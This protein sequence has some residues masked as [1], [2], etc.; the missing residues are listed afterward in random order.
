MHNDVSM[1][2]NSGRTLTDQEQQSIDTTITAE[3]VLAAIHSFKPDSA[4]VPMGLPPGLYQRYA[5]LYAPLLTLLLNTIQQ[6]GF[7]PACFLDSTVTLIPKLP[8]A[9]D[10]KPSDFR[11]IS[12]ND[13]VYRVLA[14]V[15]NTRLRPVLQRIIPLSQQAFIKGRCISRCVYL[16]RAILELLNQSDKGCFIIFNDFAKA[17]DTVDRPFLRRI[18]ETLRF[19]ET[20]CTW[21]DIM[22]NPSATYQLKLGHGLS[23]GYNVSTGVR[24]GCPLAPSLFIL[25][26]LV[27]H[28]LVASNPDIKGLPVPGPN[29]P[30]LYA[31][32]T[33]KR[34]AQES[35]ISPFADDT[36]FVQAT[37]QSMHN[38]FQALDTFYR[39]TG[40]RSYSV[41]TGVLPAGKWNTD[42]AAL[43]L[44]LHAA[45]AQGLDTL[46][47]DHAQQ[48]WKL[49]GYWITPPGGEP[50]APVKYLGPLM[51]P[52][53]VV[54]TDYSS[55]V[56]SIYTQ[57]LRL[58]QH[59]IPLLHRWKIVKTFVLSRLIYATKH[60]PMDFSP[61]K[62]GAL[63]LRYIQRYVLTESPKTQRLPPEIDRN[64]LYHPVSR[65]GLQAQHVPFHQ[66]ALR[67]KMIQLHASGADPL[68]SNAI[69]QHLVRSLKYKATV[70]WRAG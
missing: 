27:L 65:G 36:E 37:V 29:K 6:T 48:R 53:G 13:V 67:F 35:L 21:F 15:L 51:G 57:L 63:L 39:A 52:A 11:P 44:H 43:H 8:K 31:F 9:T 45:Q 1:L 16:T 18:L 20:F 50:A 24:Q 59:D 66:A 42:P 2:Q 41:K 62:P 12:V 34:L 60:C 47:Y 64:E 4:T 68:F 54:P 28:E 10:C 46:N 30:S 70:K 23:R 19:G 58:R 33:D 3:E 61:G 56:A 25:V 32:R 17:Y 26:A 38:L 7:M 5:H 22:H 69:H 40:L 14:K 49:D 55:F